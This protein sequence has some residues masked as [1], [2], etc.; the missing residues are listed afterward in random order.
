MDERKAY[1]L[2]LEERG[3]VVGYSR[4]APPEQDGISVI[5]DVSVAVARAER[6]NGYGLTLLLGLEPYAKMCPRV[7]LRAKI[8]LGNYPSL[9]LFNR[10]GYHLTDWE[11]AWQYV[12]KLL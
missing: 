8:H 2:V 9:Q 11:G 12:Y 1:L 10:A 6:G 7:G 3:S 4:F 5:A